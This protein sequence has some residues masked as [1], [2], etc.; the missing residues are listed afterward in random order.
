[1]CLVQDTAWRCRL[2][3]EFGCRRRELLVIAHNGTNSMRTAPTLE[4]ANEMLIAVLNGIEAI[5]FVVDINTQEV[6]YANQYAERSL[7]KQIK[8]GG[9]CCAEFNCGQEG[10][11]NFCKIALFVDENGNATSSHV[12]E[13]QNTVNHRWHHVQAN[14]IHW[15]D[16]RRVGLGVVTDVTDQ[17]ELEEFRLQRQLDFGHAARLSVAGEMASGL[18]HELSQP[19]TA[20]NNYLHGCMSLIESGQHDMKLLGEAIKSAH[21]QTERAGKIITHLQNFI[22]KDRNDRQWVDINQLA[23]GSIRFLDHEIQ[24]HQIHISY[25]FANLP[26]I[27]ANPIELEQVL[28]NL[29]KNAIESMQGSPFRRLDIWIRLLGVTAFE[30]EI[31]DTGKGIPESEIDQIFNP[32][33][34]SKTDGLGLGLTICRSII[35]SYGGQIRASSSLNSGS[36]FNFTLP[37][38]NHA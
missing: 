31:S 27:H 30:V 23:L 11:C 28:I 26:P 10:P 34:S 22:R 36:V 7:D 4:I 15:I 13:Y 35:E 17:K 12:C 14:A 1:M 29:L 9:I 19:L 3:F 20:A 5:I 38:E 25:D 6:V 32:F 21:V 2:S 16:G 24:R 18:A 33:T 8:V 37:L